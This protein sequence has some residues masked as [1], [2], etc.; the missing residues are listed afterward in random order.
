MQP[1]AIQELFEL[2]YGRMNATLG[3]E[4]PNT[5]FMVQ[6][7]VPLGYVDPV[8]EVIKS[9]EPQIWKITHN[10]V[11]THAI[12]FHFHDV[13]LI[14]RAGWDGS[15]KP[16]DANEVGWKETVRM[17]PLEDTI[18]AI[19]ATT[20][21][22]PFAIPDSIRPL[23][24]TM[25]AGPITV[26]DPATGGFK[27]VD[28]ALTNFSWEY[29]WHCHI[30]GHEENDMMRPTVFIPGP[31]GFPKIPVTAVAGNTQ[32][33]ISFPVAG[34]KSQ[35]KY[36][37]VTSTPGG[38]SATGFSSPIT[39]TGLTNDTAYTF[40]VSA[41]TAN[42]TIGP[43]GPS[44]SV[45][46]MA[47]AVMAPVNLSAIFTMPSVVLNWSDLSKNGSSFVIQRAMDAAFTVSLSTFTTAANVTT[48]TDSAIVPFQTYYYRVYAFNGT[49]VSGFSN[50]ASV[51][52]SN[53]PPMAPSQLSAKAGYYVVRRRRQQSPKV[54][55]VWKD[56]SNNETSFEVQR[57]ISR[58]NPVWTTI[59]RNG[60]NLTS[61]TDLLPFRNTTYLY[62]VRA[63]N[64]IGASVY[65]LEVSVKTGP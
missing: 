50:T 54:D 30:L 61:Y 49:N 64:A 46:P 53:L 16:P 2:N 29:V 56:N 52:V 20:P 35:V 25:P 41:V 5:N 62:R 60:A 37:I 4:L 8:T 48:Y 47:M 51:L 15:I 39:V 36:Y 28:N 45:I 57:S 31:A 26:V 33:T 7:T 24:P 9:D 21:S 55:L 1:K 6:T 38:I 17:N 59:G 43:F 65:S 42:G 13:Q 19:R 32:A 11:D 18:V 63:V 40:S 58:A 14:N 12:H 10:G 44:N 23:D 22:L 34:I 27:T 3:V